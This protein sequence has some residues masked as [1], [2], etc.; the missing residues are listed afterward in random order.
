M[1]NIAGSK[2]GRLT[3]VARVGTRRGSV[4]WR[5]SCECGKIKDIVSYSLMRGL[6]LSCGCLQVEATRQ[7]KK[8]HGMRHSPTYKV[9]DA[10]NQRCRN[11]NHLYYSRYGG[12][13]IDVCPR[14]RTFENFLSDM[15]E[16]PEGMTIERVNNDLGYSP[17]NCVWSTPA[18][19]SRNK[20]NNVVLE[21]NGERRCLTDWV[22][23]NGLTRS[24]IRGRLKR[25]WSVS[26]TLGTAL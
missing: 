13:G 23:F 10:M 25:G 5:C 24:A 15:A 9:W 8:T 18:I 7:S 17:E 11:P 16:K 22:G 14:W 4:L 12:R 20:S 19:Q 3:V 21:F 6:S 26:R 1:R 2:F